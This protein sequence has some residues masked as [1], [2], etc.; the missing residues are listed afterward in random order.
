MST[1]DRVAELPLEIESYELAGLTRDVSSAFTRLT[2]VVSIHGRGETGIGEDV[3]YEAKEHERLQRA[4]PVHDLAGEHTIDSFSQLLGSLDLFPEGAPEHGAWR[5]YRRWAFESAA[6]D[7]ALRQAGKPLHEVLGRD[8]QPVRFVVSLRLA[9]PPT[10]DRLVNLL[11][12]YPGTRFKLDPTSAWNAVLVEEL[13]ALEAVD[14]VD[15]KG[16][17]RGT[18]VDQPADTELY[19]LVAE[20]FPRAWIED[21]D[22]SSEEARRTLEPYYDRV[23]WDAIVHSVADI[24]ALPFPPRG[25]NIKPS[26][27]GSL[28]ALL[29]A[30]DYCRERGIVVYGG[31]QFELGPGRGQIQYLAS[32]FHPDSPNDVAPGGYN[33]PSPGPGLPS[34]PLAPSPSE[35][36]F[37]WD[38]NGC[39]V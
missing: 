33:D 22:L 38:A 19:R 17:Y 15:L 6:L 39:S 36:G 26:R 23:T 25:M 2:T 27:F 8:P 34:S 1:Y 16:A 30:H 4:G 37:R 12:E 28:R 13:A 21:P 32:L 3:T 29:D 11:A 24:E 7:L 18:V 10:T 20:G 9:D 35:T 14:T 5:N 31:G